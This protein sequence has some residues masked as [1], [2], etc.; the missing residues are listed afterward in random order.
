[1][2]LGI[3]SDI[4]AN[5][6]ALE[7]VYAHGK[8]VGVDRWICLGDII[9]YGPWPNECVDWVR[10]HC[11]FTV[12][13][14]H[15]NVGIGREEHEHFNPYARQAIEWTKAELSASSKDFLE[16]LPY[17]VRKYESIFV[18]ASPKSP[19]DW[20][21]VNSLD[22]ALECFDFFKPGACFIGHTHCPLAVIKPGPDQFHLVDDEHF[23]FNASDK[24]LINVGSV[25]QPRDNDNKASYVIFEPE[26]R[27]VEMYRLAYN[28]GKVQNQMKQLEF[29]EFLYSRL[30]RGR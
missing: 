18:H 25:G 28:I 23:T 11:E 13:G 16:T 12:L 21:Y 27:K 24:V 9:G 29:P 20:F 26:N 6:E 15:D 4:H 10:E 5:Y 17:M 30:A 1:M 3:V 2:R 22:D 14:N 7:T 8:S 19:S